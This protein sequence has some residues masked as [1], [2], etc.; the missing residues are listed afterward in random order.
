M[1]SASPPMLFL[2][3]GWQSV[4]HAAL[5]SP[6]SGAA[7]NIPSAVFCHYPGKG[8]PQ[9]PHY[10]LPFLS[11]DSRQKGQRLDSPWEHQGSSPTPTTVQDGGEVRGAIHENLTRGPP[12]RQQ[13][14][15]LHKA[16]LTSLRLAGSFSLSQEAMESFFEFLLILATLAP[17]PGMGGA[18]SRARHLAEGAFTALQLNPRQ[19]WGRGAP[20]PVN[21]TCPSQQLGSSDH[22]LFG[23][24]HR[25]W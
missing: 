9:T 25:T 21:W 19:K 2:A 13:G 3:R 11:G 24:S 17:P 4:C 18:D 1:S 7:T 23:D 5:L 8:T 10:L 12:K 22:C 14:T 6:L 15:G 20:H 16:H